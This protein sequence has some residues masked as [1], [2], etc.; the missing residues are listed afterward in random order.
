MLRNLKVALLVS[1]LLPL[2]VLV[3]FIA[4]KLFNI[5]ANIVAL[6][7]LAI[8][9]GTIVDM[10]IIL[11]ENI[12][13]IQQSFPDKPLKVIV[14]D[15]SREVSGAIVTAGLTTIISFIP[16]FSLPGVAGKLFTPLAF[17]KT[18]ALFAAIIISVFVIPPIATYVLRKNNPN[19]NHFLP[20]IGMS[21]LGVVALFFGE[22]FGLIV[23]LFGVAAIAYYKKIVDINQYKLFTIGWAII[24]VSVLLALHWHPLGEHIGWLGNQV[25]VILLLILVLLPFYVLIRYYEI[26]LK[27]ILE[28]KFIAILIPIFIL[29]LGAVIFLNTEKEFMPRLD[30]GDFLLMPT[31]L[32]H[33]GV[34]ENLKTLKKL[35]IAVA[36]LPEVEYVVGKAGRTSSALDPAPLSMFENLISYKTEYILDEDGNLMRFKVNENGEFETKSGNFVTSGS[37]V[38]KSKLIEDTS[39]KYYRNWRKHIT[40]I[41]DIWNE[42]IKVTRLPGVTTSPK[43]QPIETRMVMLQTGMRGPLGIKVKGQDLDEVEKFGLELEKVLKSTK[44]ILSESVFAE[45]TIG[46]PYLLFDIDRSKISRYGLS[47]EQVQSAIEIGV[48]G[49]V[50]SEAIEERERFGIRVRYPRELRS[51]PEDLAFIYIDL[52]NGTSLPIEEFVSIRYEK[53]PQSIKSEDGFLVTNVI[54]D[55]ED[56]ISEV[57]AVANAKLE[58]EKKLKTNELKVPDGLSFEFSGTYKE[59]LLSAQTLAF[60]IPICLILI[61]IILY[62]QFKSALTSLIVFSGIAVAFAGGFILIWLYGQ[63]WFLNFSMSEINFREVFHMGTINLSVAVWVGFIVLFG[64]ATDDGVIMATYLNQ[65]FSQKPTK[66]IE[67][68][69]INVIAAGKKRLLPCLMTTATTILALLPVLTASGKGASIMVPMAIP[70]LGGMFMAVITLF[71]V[72]L[73]YCWRKELIFNKNIAK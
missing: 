28:Q 3:V 45:R 19:R 34:E 61:L 42:I 14:L 55:K 21:I 27:W 50:I 18:A 13:Q 22:W 70:C 72:P 44:G 57:S 12:V 25:F 33:A 59:H 1:S 8:A 67:D 9:I 30:E 24:L 20:E 52:P 73:L 36:S 35:D 43:L 69:R 46:K 6:S 40:K 5:E 53:G 48:G 11:S 51:S 41:D 7:G 26:I 4:M 39:G 32:P 63:S 10:G 56:D 23:L 58:I 68:I 47:V 71:V 15:A 62:L 66:G 60:I 2:T 49:K 37:S 17:T 65:S 31:S 29:F 16:V 38:H 64:I 54:F